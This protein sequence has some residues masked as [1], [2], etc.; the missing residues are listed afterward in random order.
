MEE[1]PDAT[2]VGA[3]LALEVGA[4]LLGY[5]H[6][7][8]GSGGEFWGLRPSKRNHRAWT[9][10]AL[11]DADADDEC[12]VAVTVAS[13][14]THTTHHTGALA[15]ETVEQIMAKVTN[16]LDGS[17]GPPP[18]SKRPKHFGDKF[19]SAPYMKVGY[20]EG[21]SLYIDSLSPGIYFYDMGRLDF[22]PQISPSDTHVTIKWTFRS[23]GVV[24][25]CVPFATVLGL[26]LCFVPFGDKDGYTVFEAD[27]LRKILQ[28]ALSVEIGFWW[29]RRLGGPTVRYP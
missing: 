11:H 24:P 18:G 23:T 10:A 7:A 9:D 8:S 19:R 20:K 15:Q 27:V 14:T 6:L 21:N 1:G 4:L 12:P 2:E 26:V 25:L 22:P 28:E 5:V 29:T 16:A 3:W 13:S 17:S